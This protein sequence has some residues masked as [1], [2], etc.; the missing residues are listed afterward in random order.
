[1]AMVSSSL[2][3]D[4]RSLVGRQRE[5]ARLHGLL[6]QTLDGR[7]SLVLVSGEAGIGKTTLVRYLTQQA[8]ERDAFVLS[9]GCY[10]LTTTPPYGPWSEIFDAYLPRDDLPGEVPV[11]LRSDGSATGAGSQAA[12]FAGVRG[13]FES[14]AATRTLILVLED[15]HWSDQAS[16]DLLRYLSRH[17]GDS[18]VLIV[19]TYRNDE[20]TRSHPLFHLLPAIVRESDTEH[21]EL[22]RLASD[23]IRELVALHGLSEKDRARLAAYLEQR[24]GGNPFFA[25]E[26]LRAMESE[27]ILNTN[28]DQVFLG[29]FDNASLPSI[30]LQVIE[31]RLARIDPDARHALEVAAVIGQE[32][33][34]ELWETVS[35]LGS[36][37]LDHV[38]EQALSAH[39]LEE[40][41]GSRNGRFTHALM[42]EVLYAGMV[43]TRRWARHREIGEAFERWPR[44]DP[45]AVAYH[46]QQAGDDRAID[47]LIQAGVRAENSYAWSTA[48][49]RFEAAAHLMEMVKERAAERGWLLWRIAMSLRW[50]D[51]ERAVLRDEEARRIAEET[52]DR[53]LAAISRSHR[54]LMLCFSGRVR[55]GI[56][57]MEA[58]LAEHDRLTPD[59]R[60]RLAGEVNP[61][62]GTAL[63]WIALVGRYRECL[64]M[65]ERA[66]P[67]FEGIETR[68]TEGQASMLDS[69]GIAGMQAGSAC[70]GMASSFAMLGHPEMAEPLQKRAVEIFKGVNHHI[71]VGT[72]AMNELSYIT[73]PYYADRRERREYWAEQAVS[74]QARA[75][76]AVRDDNVP[77]MNRLP[78]LVIEGAWDEVNEL[79]P[80]HRRTAANAASRINSTV[81]LATVARHQGRHDLA[82]D[83]VRE[84]LPLGPDTEPGDTQ[85]Q[86]AQA[87]Q[88]LA[89][90][91]ALDNGDLVAAREWI[92][93]HDRWLEWSGATLGWAESHLLWSR[94][95][96]QA[97][98]M[99][100]A[101]RHA[102]RAR[103]HA[104]KPRQPLALLA[105]HRRLGVIATAEK[106]FAGAEEHLGKSLTLAVVCAAPFEEALT[107]L[108]L[109]ELHAAT[110]RPDE[111]WRHLDRM[112]AICTPLQATPALER[113]TAIAAGLSVRRGQA[114]YPAG[115]TPR[116]VEILGLI[117]SG[118]SNREMADALFISVRTAERHVSNIYNKLGV[119]SRVEASRFAV[120]HG[121]TGSPSS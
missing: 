33:P 52:G 121:L 25:I 34:F 73:L 72:C 26:L 63:F 78:L 43:P 91:L 70:A 22:G 35:G 96:Q 40:V 11:L 62:R 24:T 101:R 104:T 59:E 105:V 80:L 10:D 5:Q 19:V 1:M 114:A 117:A 77:R 81:A 75:L 36:S 51:P 37:A 47:W 16:L 65:G 50:L 42:R 99:A 15:L 17:L 41:S 3:F 49:E 107:L 113:A 53:A 7:G 14:L 54:G 71:M 45:D 89:A 9:G 76:G 109:A 85:F 20:L 103:A 13:F 38:I 32:V 64:D 4:S 79:M 94:C 108:S 23:A 119:N 30:V 112:R 31:R 102:D 90:E 48:A 95:Y 46:F 106:C 68:I 12:M 116:E 69:T 115:L 93:A 6:D 111:A 118:M 28:N 57:E 88:R 55:E 98:D 56:V 84:A 18:G 44:P 8:E 83:Q 39:I 29:A 86:S 82:W 58:S 120:D 66:L 110:G 92:E 67:E 21:I 100:L 97:A 74:A 61:A 60:S 27:G 2:P 87:L